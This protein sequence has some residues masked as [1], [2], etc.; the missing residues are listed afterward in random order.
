MC[1]THECVINI[2]MYVV[3]TKI[4]PEDFRAILKYLYL[5]DEKVLLPNLG[6][7]I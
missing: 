6:I 4:F 1:Y 2:T 3:L 5:R 7:V